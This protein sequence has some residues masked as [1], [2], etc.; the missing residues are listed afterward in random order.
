M[1]LVLADHLSS[2]AQLAHYSHELPNHLKL[3]VPSDGLAQAEE[4]LKEPQIKATL[5][6]RSTSSAPAKP[7]PTEASSRLTALLTGQ[8]KSSATSQRVVLDAQ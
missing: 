5:G 4:A 6:D 7:M 3:S 2:K 8:S 1:S